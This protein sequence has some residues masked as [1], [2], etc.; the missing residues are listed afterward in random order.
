MKKIFNI[1]L[2]ALFCTSFA[3]AQLGKTFEFTYEG[4]TLQY[5]VADVNEAMVSEQQRAK[6]SGDVKIPENVTFEGEKYTVTS[7]RWKA[8]WKCT[9]LTS[10]TI[11]NSV[12]TIGMGLFGVALV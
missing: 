7:I 6:I 9:N 3:Q 11:P 5:E 8:F 1:V 12:T 2:F 10:I 4:Q